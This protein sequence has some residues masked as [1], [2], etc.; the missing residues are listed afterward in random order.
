MQVWMTKPI[1]TAWGVLG[2]LRAFG[3]T[4]VTPPPGGSP[5]DR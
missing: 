5:P 2:A 1:T 4:K 3:K